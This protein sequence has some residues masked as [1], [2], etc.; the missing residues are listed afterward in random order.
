MFLW[1]LSDFVKT[2]SLKE[3]FLRQ[4]KICQFDSN[5]RPQKQLHTKTNIQF[6]SLE[7]FIETD[8]TMSINCNKSA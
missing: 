7:R 8:F 1:N 3:S 2:Y 4:P 5:E 6:S